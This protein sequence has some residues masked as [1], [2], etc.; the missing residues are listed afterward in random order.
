VR[1][2]DDRVSVLVPARRA[3]E[4]LSWER[5]TETCGRRSE[6]LILEGSG[7]YDSF[8]HGTVEGFAGTRLSSGALTHL[9]ESPSLRYRNLQLER[10]ASERRNLLPQIKRSQSVRLIRWRRTCKKNPPSQG[11]KLIGW[12][13]TGVGQELRR[14]IRRKELANHL[15]V[16]VH[17]HLVVNVDCVKKG[18][19]QRVVALWQSNLELNRV[20]EISID[21]SWVR[22]GSLEG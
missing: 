2:D 1:Y 10:L 9:K 7:F 20:A 16:Q 6:A 14:I 12:I 3:C 19:V 11:D 18:A 8:I 21:G 13:I 22:W 15:P 5:G 4:C 17:G